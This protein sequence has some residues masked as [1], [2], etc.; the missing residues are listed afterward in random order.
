[1]HE[2]HVMHNA[3]GQIDVKVENGSFVFQNAEAYWSLIWANVPRTPALLIKKS[4][5]L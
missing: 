3:V 4:T 1:M 2:R 5:P